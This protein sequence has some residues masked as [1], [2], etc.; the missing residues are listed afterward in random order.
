MFRRTLFSACLF[1]S[2]LILSPLSA[3]AL[4][5]TAQSVPKEEVVRIGVSGPF[6]GGSAPMGESMRN[7][8]RL[9]TQEIN[10]VGGI[11]GKRIELIERDDQANNET[12]A[13][14]AREFVQLKVAATI[15]IVNTGV[16][17]ASIDAYQQAKIPLMVAV[18]TGPALTK[19]FAPP[20]ATDNYIFRVAP[21]L[22]ME[23]RVL[24]AHLKRAGIGA[25]AIMA[26]STAYGDAGLKALRSEC[27]AQQIRIEYEGRFN[28]G[29]QDMS[30]QIR[31]GKSSA[32][33][34]LVAWGIGPE[35]AVL[36]KGKQQLGWKVPL[37]GSW[38][39]S[40]RTFID[41]AAKTGEGALTTQTF[42]QDFGSIGK[43][44]FL[45]SYKHAYNTDFIASPMSAAQGYD[46]M[47]LLANAMR[48][49]GSLDG[50]KIKT[51]LENLT[52]RHEGAITN[53][54]RPFSSHDHDAMTQNMILL[55]KISD[56]RVV[57]ASARDEKRSALGLRKEKT[58]Q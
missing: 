9:A 48:L 29:E 30:A 15:G 16:G 8:I 27:E 38:T 42:I 45:Y 39:I 36:A 34:A 2:P 44:A 49:A 28:L 40:M 3:L 53:Y 31:Q 51:A 17:M 20:A 56:G 10:R 58:E 22:D 50:S 21:T 57:F 4:P 13:K 24:A 7:G 43:N 18:S 12:G 19:K 25:I 33:K 23:A 47:H 1:L 14:I 6:S 35:L 32:A 54:F 26:D 11:N 5:A 41:G 52:V 55:G 46:G 37:L